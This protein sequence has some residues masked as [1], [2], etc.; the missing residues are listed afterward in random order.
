MIH[1]YHVFLR[2]S[3]LNLLNE[4]SDTC[5]ILYKMEYNYILPQVLSLMCVS[6]E[7]LYRTPNLNQNVS[8]NLSA[9]TWKRQLFIKDNQPFMSIGW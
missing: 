3:R 6:L 4:L 9:K 5:P 8:V 7:L 1:L 2:L